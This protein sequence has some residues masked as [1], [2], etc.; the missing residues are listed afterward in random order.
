MQCQPMTL[1][2]S[3][4]IICIW[5]QSMHFLDFLYTDSLKG[6]KTLALPLLVRDG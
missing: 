1:Q 6:R 3:L 4:M 5:K 2:D